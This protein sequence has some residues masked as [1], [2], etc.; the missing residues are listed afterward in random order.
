MPK[1][2]PVGIL[3]L[4]MEFL[5]KGKRMARLVWIKTKNN[6][7]L[8]EVQPNKESAY[9]LGGFRGIPLTMVQSA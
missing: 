4:K 2:L 1:A 5:H 3:E 8:R 7:P 6:T 9:P